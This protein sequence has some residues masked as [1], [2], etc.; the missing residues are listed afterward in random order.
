ASQCPGRRL[1][2]P[3]VGRIVPFQRCLTLVA[4][5]T[6][7][8]PAAFRGG[9]LVCARTGDD[10]RRW[11]DIYGRGRHAFAGTDDWFTN[12]GPASPHVL[13]ACCGGQFFGWQAFGRRSVDRLALVLRLLFRPLSLG[14]R[15]CVALER[16]PLA[17][18]LPVAAAAAA[19]TPP[20]AARRAVPPTS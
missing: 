15:G 17:V 9:L 12:C 6:L 19:A 13:L 14:L 1:E 2:R 16:W 5:Q 3:L 20:P 8:P 18:A 11:W 10:R 7:A 4:K